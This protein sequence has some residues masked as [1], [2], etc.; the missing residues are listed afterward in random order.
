MVLFL[1]FSPDEVME[2]VGRI[3]D[4]QRKDKK[5][6]AW[7]F[8]EC[9][10]W[11]DRNRFQIIP[12]YGK[13]YHISTQARRVSE[14][15]ISA[16]AMKA[17]LQKIYGRYWRLPN[18]LGRVAVGAV[19]IIGIG[20]LFTAVG[21]AQFGLSAWLGNVPAT[22]II[23]GILLGIILVPQGINEIWKW[24]RK[25]DDE[26]TAVYQQSIL[27]RLGRVFFS[28]CP[29]CGKYLGNLPLDDD[30][31]VRCSCGYRMERKTRN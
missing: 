17:D 7:V 15:E 14:N 26:K 2:E 19:K 25:R 20:L 5:P 10:A 31:S 12:V 28:R 30:G 27:R 18:V 6:S 23:I 13:F 9:I 24:S 22:A 3:L 11:E 29:K 8:N 1:P 4:H 21:L 16:D